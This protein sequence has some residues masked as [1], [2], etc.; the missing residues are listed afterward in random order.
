MF[1]ILRSPFPRAAGGRISLGVPASTVDLRPPQLVVGISLTLPE[2]EDF[3]EGVNIFPALIDTAYNRTLEIDE[4]HLVQWAGFHK[5]WL[6][7]LEKNRHLRGRAYGIFDA[8]IWLHRL[9]YLKLRRPLARSPRLLECHQIRVMEPIG[10]PSPR[11][12]IVGLD[13]LVT[14]GL[15]LSVDGYTGNFRISQSLRSWW[16]GPSGHSAETFARGT[17]RNAASDD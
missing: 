13:A 1:T 5:D 6:I 17:H 9:P 8:N 11:L 2:E 7:S 12:P 16:F 3:P 10:D 15:R 4:Q 14:D